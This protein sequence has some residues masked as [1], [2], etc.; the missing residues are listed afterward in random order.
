MGDS[1]HRR[2]RNQRLLSSLRKSIV[3]KPPY[4][5]GTLQLPDSCFSL[6]YKTAKDSPAARFA[7]DPITFLGRVFHA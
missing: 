1:G 7:Q 3:D 5:N 6:F 4:I 2:S